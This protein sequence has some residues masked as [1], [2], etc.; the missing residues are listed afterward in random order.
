VTLNENPIF[1]TQK[2]LVHRSGITVAVLIAALIGLSLLSGLIAYLI[3]PDN[4]SFPTP[5]DAGQFFYGW[6]LGVEVVTLLIG[7]GRVSHTLANERKIGLWDSNHLTPL[8]SWQLV[9][10]YWFGPP[11]REFYMGMILAGIGL[12]TVL[13][14]KLPITFWLGTQILIFSSALFLG[15]LALLAGMFTQRPQNAF[16][17]IGPLFFLTLFF[18]MTPRFL[19]SNFIL[20]VYPIVNL[21]LVSNPPA[22]DAQIADWIGSPDIFGL[23]VYP[24]L[25][26]I[27]LQLLVGLFLWRMVIRK[28]ENPFRPALLRWEVVALF[29]IFVLFQHAL[30]WG[31]WRGQYVTAGI[32]KETAFDAANFSFLSPIVHFATILLA[33]VV[34]ALVSLQPESIRKQ[35]LGPGIRAPG[36]IL[37]QSSALIALV[38]TA[39]AGIILFTQFVRSL[40]NSWEIYLIAVGNL[41]SFSLIFSLLLEYCRLR[42]KRRAIGFVALWLFVLW[43][44]PLILGCVFFNGAIAKF[45]LLAPGCIA[46]ADVDNENVQQLFG[47]LNCLLAIVGAHL[48]IAFLLFLAWRREWQKLLARAV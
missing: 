16:A 29:T 22:M 31:G 41:L 40:A 13:L 20:P 25:L 2:R 38:L 14:A 26:T 33:M 28:T 37:F 23:P 36:K 30:V 4:F 6:I 45:S 3:E 10:G 32:N 47:N 42:H 15:L 44:L 43:L 18:F 8:Q 12:I 5:Q 48:L 1:L 11:L 17:F 9:V 39:I 19:L 21:F 34:L 46:L 27:V 7:L 24:L 35:A